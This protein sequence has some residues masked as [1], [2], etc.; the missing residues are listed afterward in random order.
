MEIIIG[1]AKHLIAEREKL[2]AQALR[3]AHQ[4]AQAAWGLTDGGLYPDAGQYGV[5]TIRVKHMQRGTNANTAEKWDFNFTT[6][7][8]ATPINNNVLED[9]YIGIIGFAFPN[10]NRT[11]DLMQLDAGGRTLPVIDIE[12]T[13]AMEEPIMLLKQPLVVQENQPIKMAFSVN[14]QGRQ[15]IIPLGFALVKTAKLISQTPT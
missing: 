12:E 2:M 10:A 9:V 15:K 1:E 5:T 6:I 11:L 13:H 7:G 14:A 3:Q 8:W 4:K